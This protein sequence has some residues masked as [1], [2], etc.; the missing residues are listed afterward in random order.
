MKYHSLGKIQREK[1]FIRPQVRQKLNTQKVSYHNE[2]ERFIMVCSLLRQKLF[3][4]HFS[5]EHFQPLI[6]PKLWYFPV[7]ILTITRR[8]K[9]QKQ[10]VKC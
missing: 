8:Q 10:T 3:T 1:I 9:E 2:I 5:H 6:F 7:A 4:T